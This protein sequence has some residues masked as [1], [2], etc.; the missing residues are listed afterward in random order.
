M[1]E[2]SNILVPEGVQRRPALAHQAQASF[3]L[4][5]AERRI[6]A[7]AVVSSVSC[8]DPADYRTVIADESGLTRFIGAYCPNIARLF[9][10]SKPPI[11]EL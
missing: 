9:A 4:F 10:P 7:I 3:E 6:L 11:A 1:P 8:H 2:R 5:D